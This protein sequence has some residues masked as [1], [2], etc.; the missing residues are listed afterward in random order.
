MLNKPDEL[1]SD[2]LNYHL[3]NQNSSKPQ[4]N[5]NLNTNSNNVNAS[6]PPATTYTVTNS[7][8]KPQNN[9]NPST[10]PIKPI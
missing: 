1:T 5:N 3:A 7:I 9:Q 8:I 4:Q 2:V 6:K 10:N